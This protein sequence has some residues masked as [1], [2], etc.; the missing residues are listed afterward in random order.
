MYLFAWGLCFVPQGASVRLALGGSQGR[1]GTVP[2]AF[3]RAIVYDP[4]KE[5]H[6]TVVIR[7]DAGFFSYFC[8]DHSTEEEFPLYCLEAFKES[9]AALE[10]TQIV[11]WL[12][13]EEWADDV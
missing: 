12:E 2:T 6:L 11:S 1:E 10:N 5:C 13:V 9:A 4:A 7:R 8:A 3:P